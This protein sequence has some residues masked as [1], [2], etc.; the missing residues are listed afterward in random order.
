MVSVDRLQT[1]YGVE[2]SSVE[3]ALLMRHRA[4]LF[5]I[6]GTVLLFTAS[7]PDWQWL[8]LVIGLVS[9][10]SFL[11]LAHQGAALNAAVTRVVYADWVAL[12]LLLL[13]C[14]VKLLTLSEP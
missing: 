1:L 2:L 5:G 14:G 4:V 12:F 10:T 9:V 6:L 13:A 8:G 3:L 7:R 11:L